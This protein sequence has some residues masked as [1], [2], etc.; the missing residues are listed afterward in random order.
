[1]KILYLEDNQ[2]DAELVQRYIQT[3][4]HTLEIVEKLE[5]AER[6][7]DA[8]TDLLLVDILIDNHRSGLDYIMQLR[9]E[10]FDRKS[11]V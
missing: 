3:T 1:M 8:E 4:D 6:S 2:M 11:V 9:A 5:A 10:G 7:L